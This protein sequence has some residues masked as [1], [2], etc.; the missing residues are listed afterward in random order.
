MGSPAIFRKNLE[1]DEPLFRY[2]RKAPIVRS[3]SEY[4]EDVHEDIGP[5]TP[6]RPPNKPIPKPV[7]LDKEPADP[8]LRNLRGSSSNEAGRDR[9]MD[10]LWRNLSC[11]YC[12]VAIVLGTAF[13]LS[14]IIALEV[15][16]FYYQ[17]FHIYL[18]GLSLLFLMTVY[19]SNC[20]RR[21]TRAHV[22]PRC[23]QLSTSRERDRGD[24]DSPMNNEEMEGYSVRQTG[25]FYLRAGALL[26]GIGAMLYSS[27]ELGQ[28][29][30]MHLLQHVHHCHQEFFN[31]TSVFRL[32]F[33]FY[34]LYFIFVNTRVRRGRLGALARFGLMH[35]L[36][37]NICIWLGVLIDETRH[38]LETA[39][40]DPE[41]I[42]PPGYHDP[43]PHNHTIQLPH[44][45][46]IGDF[47]SKKLFYYAKAARVAFAS[48]LNASDIS[49]P[50]CRTATSL[51]QILQY[52]NPVLYPCIV[53]SSLI[54]AAL[55]YIRWQNLDLDR[56]T[57]LENVQDGIRQKAKK[58]H[59][60]YRVDCEGA[61][62]GLFFGTGLVLLTMI[63]MILFF[64]WIWNPEDFY[65]RTAV[66]QANCLEI[67][68]YSTTL[69][70]VVLAFWRIRSLKFECE[71]GSRL[72]DTLLVISQMGS[73]VLPA[74]IIISV[75]HTLSKE[76]TWEGITGIVAA[77]LETLQSTI[78]TLF[79]LDATR[80]VTTNAKHV[81]RKP[82][83]Q[84]VTFLLVCNVSLWAID[85]LEA[86]RQQ[87]YPQQL[88]FYG[89]AAWTMI[90]RASMPLMIF[91]RFHSSVCLSEVWKS[92]YKCKNPSTSD[93]AV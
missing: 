90:T 46:S 16:P 54:S 80:R 85:S 79:L 89:T 36:A 50:S 34:Q 72:D 19:T 5:A 37:T 8:T 45:S 76:P 3:A 56:K 22:T 21:R 18:Y 13:A 52:L 47:H 83:R 62:I 92:A 27:L 93:V 65:Y 70:A 84:L 32:L 17:G 67:L 53:E 38:E 60:Q 75:H 29:I 61:T 15:T 30:E 24:V 86:W 33:Y 7:I 4:F 41:T 31:F 1:V 69:I 87:L 44:N 91:Y 39:V 12:L 64:V 49:S 73:Y 6:L 28:G 35:M 43:F 88:T 78:Q 66:L 48:F 26:F 74:Y 55:I 25:S 42:R 57:V 9:S 71:S 77:C 40:F 11:L 2:V 63:S 58:T 10:Y 81:E 68:L 82:G 20:W 14:E 51:G 23:L 59:M